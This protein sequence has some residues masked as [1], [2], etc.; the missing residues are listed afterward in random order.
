[1]PTTR[2]ERSMKRMSLTE[3]QAEA[4]ELLRYILGY[5]RL[6]WLAWGTKRREAQALRWYARNEGMRN[7]K[8]APKRGRK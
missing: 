5:H 6:D 3:H 2:A 8:P 4:A 1:M 7:T